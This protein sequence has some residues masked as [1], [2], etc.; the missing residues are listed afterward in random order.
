MRIVTPL[1]IPP[2]KANRVLINVHG[3]GF[4][5]DSG[6]LTETIPLANLT[7][8]KVVAV[9]YRLAPEHPFPAAVDD[10]VAVY[11]ELLKTYRPKN[12]G[13]YGTSAGAILT[14]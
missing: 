4:V 3:G 9:L 5:V 1:T 7:R 6:S 13:L 10:T 14:G 8:T 11:K 2:D 12:I